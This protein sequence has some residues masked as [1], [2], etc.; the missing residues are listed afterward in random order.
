[1]DELIIT[2][3]D[4][5]AGHRVENFIELSAHGG[6]MLEYLKDIGVKK[7]SLFGV[8][9]SVL[10]V[11]NCALELGIEIENLVG[12]RY[13]EVY[14]PRRKKPIIFIN[15]DKSTGC[16]CP[17]VICA[18][19]AKFPWNNSVIRK[20]GFYLIDHLVNYS[21][22]K[23]TVIK[24]I[25]E[26]TSSIP[27][28]LFGLVKIPSLWEIRTPTDYEKK[29]STVNGMPWLDLIVEKALLPN[30]ITR[31]KFTQIQK[32]YSLEFASKGDCVFGKD[33]DG[34]FIRI[35][36]GSRFVTDVPNSAKN[37]IHIYGNSASNGWC[38]E[39]KNTIASYLQRQINQKKG[40]YAVINNVCGHG[41]NF[42]DI[43]KRL[44]YDNICS[45]DIVL[46]ISHDIP[47]YLINK[48]KNGFLTIDCNPLFQRPH[49]MGEVFLQ[50]Q[51]YTPKAHEKI[52]AQISNAIGV[53]QEAT[54][55]PKMLSLVGDG[56]LAKDDLPEL[57]KW[58]D[59]IEQHRIQIGSIVMNC[60]PFTLGHRHLIEY[61]AS[62]SERLFI[63]VVEEDKSFFP[64]A[65]RIELVR[66]GIA[67]LSNVTV[68]PSGEFIISQRTFK[69]YSNKADVQDAVIDPSLDVNIFGKYIAP[70][71]GINVR[72]AGEEPLDKVTLQYNDTMQRVLPR[73]GIQFEVIP[74]KEFGG[75]VISASRVRKLLKDK[76][77][78]EIAKIVP[79]TT[80]DY[81]VKKY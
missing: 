32:E 31:E 28:V 62:K 22:I 11:Y 5:D 69:E 30:G 1:M 71:L 14:S 15:H 13:F 77:F 8:N 19:G 7:I 39:D 25:D 4:Y 29:L 36:N 70:K 41:R 3:E 55:K 40:K 51:H 16:E 20:K 9:S 50:S 79:K 57:A 23:H 56:N 54:H 61:A 21:L 65:D 75:E 53:W 81:L 59:S 78:D 38:T 48:D 35:V 12:D 76:K 68:L 74:R 17:I 46:I 67:H 60:N 63:F 27:G 66:K 26:I 52:A 37:C 44:R 33:I 49:D 42:K 45:G 72:F 24:A 2:K 73:Y 64:F 34:K 18:N 43:A 10:F 58:L 47:P 6:N 80:F